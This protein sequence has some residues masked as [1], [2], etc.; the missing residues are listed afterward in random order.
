M[1]RLSLSYIRLLVSMFMRHEALRL[2]LKEHLAFDQL[3]QGVY[4]QLPPFA[5]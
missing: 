5:H 2:G 4:G 1:E 3:V